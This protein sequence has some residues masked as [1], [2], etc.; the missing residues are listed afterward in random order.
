ML[1]LAER[2]IARGVRCDIVIAI[3]KGQLL[4]RVPAGVRLVELGKRKTIH[5]VFALAK[6]LRKERPQVVLSTVFAANIAALMANIFSAHA[7]RIVLREANQTA[8]DL[9]DSGTIAKHLNRLAL[10]CLYQRAEAVIAVAE[11]VAAGLI[12]TGVVEKPRLHVIRNPAPCSLALRTSN[13]ACA[14]RPMILA[15]GRLEPQKNHASLLRSFAKVQ[16]SLDATLVILGEGSLLPSLQNEARE[17]G[18]DSTVTFAGYV[19]N[20]H[21]WMRRA[22]VFVHPSRFEGMSNVL[23][24]ALACGC[25]IVA[26][27]CPGGSREVLADGKY[28]TL[29]PVGDD[30][31]LTD[32]I[33]QVLRGQ[34]AF[35][36]AGEHLR[37]FDIEH[38]TDAYLSVL[39]PTDRKEA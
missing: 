1:A 15:C 10:A 9:N 25:P 33:L 30:A 8:L 2:F 24:E 13:T 6:Y 36:D 38:V 34:V 39:F 29:V 22:S 7:T 4:G 14:D 12:L 5:A 11:S 3:S 20:P 17:L 35:P 19:R 16:N 18:I 37:K 32:A 28:G 27:D 23:I 21:E 31:A 26:T